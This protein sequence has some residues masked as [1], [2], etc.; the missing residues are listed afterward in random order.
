[1]EQSFVCSSGKFKARTI[2]FSSFVAEDGSHYSEFS[3]L[4]IFHGFQFLPSSM[5]LPEALSSPGR[6]AM[7]N[8]PG[9]FST[10]HAYATILVPRRYSVAE[11]KG[12][13]W[14]HLTAARRS[15]RYVMRCVSGAVRRPESTTA[16]APYDSVLHSSPLT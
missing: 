10:Q 5:R 3:F 7:Y 8:S 13:D 11:P 9:Q 16:S 14:W 2:S 15:R 12:D 6:E 4:G 1:M